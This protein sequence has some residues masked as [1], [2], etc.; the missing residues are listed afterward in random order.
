MTVDP[1]F[2]VYADGIDQTSSGLMGYSW[3]L[4]MVLELRRQGFTSKLKPCRDTHP[5]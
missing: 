3:A 1:H 5:E 4:A 2:H